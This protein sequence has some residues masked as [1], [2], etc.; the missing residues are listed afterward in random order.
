M[1]WEHRGRQGLASRRNLPARGPTVPRSPG[2][3]LCTRGVRGQRPGLPAFTLLNSPG[4]ASGKAREP[5]ADTLAYTLLWLP[6]GREGEA[7]CITALAPPPLL[8]P[9]GLGGGPCSTALRPPAQVPGRGARHR[10]GVPVPMLPPPDAFTEV[11]ALPGVRIRV[12]VPGGAEGPG[13][14]AEEGAEERGAEAAAGGGHRCGSKPGEQALG[15]RAGPGIPVQVSG[16]GSQPARGRGAGPPSHQENE[17]QLSAGQ[18]DGLRV[19]LKGSWARDGGGG[20]VSP[21]P[22]A[23]HSHPRH[24]S[25]SV[26]PPSASLPPPPSRALDASLQELFFRGI[27][28]AQPGTGVGGLEPVQ[29]QGCWGPSGRSGRADRPGHVCRV[30]PEVGQE[31][32]GGDGG[33]LEP[34][35]KELPCPAALG[36]GI[37]QNPPDSWTGLSTQ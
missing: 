13:E 32:R 10:P 35:R 19:S 12:R 25:K 26:F 16:A 36:L 8:L 14:E 11:P 20:G 28:D 7:G 1:A 31:G 3:G 5:L 6:G 33:I 24:L 17:G 29:E 9:S 23:C 21:P 2:C 37:Q 27:L 34:S 22:S 18:D 4:P 30:N 15:G